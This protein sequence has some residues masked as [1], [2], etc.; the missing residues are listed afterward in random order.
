MISTQ[1]PNDFINVTLVPED[2]NQPSDIVY[3]FFNQEYFD[4]LK[5]YSFSLDWDDYADSQAAINCEDTFY[6]FHYNKVYTTAM[7]LDRYKRGLGRA[8]HLGIKEIDSRTC[9]SETNTFPVNDIVRNFDFLFFVFNLFLSILTPLVFIP[10]LFI[11]HLIAFIWPVL[12][13]LLVFLG[14]YIT[15][16][17]VDSA[18][19]LYYYIASIGDANLGG[20]VISVATILQIIK[21]G[22][23]VIFMVAAGIAFI[24][25]TLKYLINISFHLI[26]Y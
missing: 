10:L 23:K 2:P 16:L 9:K 17:G 8:K 1:T 18:I 6:E 14:G 4:L 21:Q 5:S 7:F 26:F 13:Y 25:F 24:A 19:D 11:A 20:P 15:Y 22:V 3:K 12:K